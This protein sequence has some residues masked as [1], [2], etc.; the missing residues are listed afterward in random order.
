MIARPT[1]LN[2]RP[3]RKHGDDNKSPTSQ[4]ATPMMRLDAI[5][6]R[7]LAL[8]DPLLW[9]FCN[10]KSPV[11]S[12]QAIN[13]A[14]HQLMKSSNLNLAFIERCV[15]GSHFILL[16]LICKQSRLSTAECELS[17]EMFSYLWSRL[18]NAEFVL[19]V[20]LS[21]SGTEFDR[22]VIVF[23]VFKYLTSLGRPI[24]TKLVGLELTNMTQEV[25][26]Y[27]N[28]GCLVTL[29]V[30]TETWEERHSRSELWSL[31]WFQSRLS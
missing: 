9:S 14:I 4:M 13:H 29:Q 22:L 3:D 26:D 19:S 6:L 12:F 18:G 23:D 2:V 1:K 15:Q 21:T 27:F 8:N 11:V 20:L 31:T 24:A 28:D 17:S 10:S 16:H 5:H 7:S 25:E 30:L